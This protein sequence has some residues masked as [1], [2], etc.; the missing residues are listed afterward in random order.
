[1]F[2]KLI[3]RYKPYKLQNTKYLLRSSATN[4][5]KTDENIN[6]D[7]IATAY[8]YKSTQEL[9]RGWLVFKLCSYKSLVDHLSQ[10]N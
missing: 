8:G 3:N 5:A 1:M 10:V 2:S 6:F 4:L 7:S 9:F